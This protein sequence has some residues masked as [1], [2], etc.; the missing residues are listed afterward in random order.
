MEERK[1]MHD[2]ELK[3]YERKHDEDPSL[4]DSSNLYSKEK[5]TREKEERKK[6]IDNFRKIL[7]QI[8]VS[9]S[10]Y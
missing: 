6:Q 8:F 10:P 1:A 4:F 7:S 9:F 2:E 3:V 5:G